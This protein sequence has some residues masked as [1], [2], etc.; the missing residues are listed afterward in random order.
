[1]AGV[2]Q[3]TSEYSYAA[4]LM[5]GT[6]SFTDG[7]AGYNRSTLIDAYYDDQTAGQA[8]GTQANGSKGVSTAALKGSRK[9]DVPAAVILDGT[10]A[11]LYDG[12]GGGALR[13]PPES[14]WRTS[15]KWPKNRPNGHIIDASPKQML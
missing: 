3:S 4:G 11:G 9:T 13:D 2:N 7:F 6:G 8:A 5:P 15:E 10:F 1:M 14:V 12:H